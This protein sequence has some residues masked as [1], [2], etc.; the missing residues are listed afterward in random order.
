MKI[1]GLDSVIALYQT[2]GD[3]LAALVE[4]PLG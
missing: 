4:T 1:I 3:A 2:L